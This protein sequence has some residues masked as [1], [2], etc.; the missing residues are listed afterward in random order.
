MRAAARPTLMLLRKVDLP[1]RPEITGPFS[2][3]SSTTRNTAH[4]GRHRIDAL[5]SANTASARAQAATSRCATSRPRMAKRSA[6][7]KLCSSESAGGRR[8]RFGESEWTDCN[9][10]RANAIR[11]LASRSRSSI[12]ARRTEGRRYESATRDR[13]AEK[14]LWRYRCCRTRESTTTIPSDKK[15]QKNAVPDHLVPCCRPIAPLLNFDCDTRNTITDMCE[16]TDRQL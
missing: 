9:G 2:L 16:I 7:T 15:T 4:R 1:G 14:S 5:R 10:G 12:F 6:Q 13:Q 3:A 8:H 11:I